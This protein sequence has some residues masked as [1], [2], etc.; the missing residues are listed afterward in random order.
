MFQCLIL[1]SL[2]ITS[3]HNHDDEGVYVVNIVINK[4]T[5][6]QTVTKNTVMPIDVSMTRDDKGVIHN[7]KMEIVNATSSATV[8]TLLDKHHHE[9]GTFNY[10][11]AAYKPQT[12]GSFKLKITVTDDD[13]LQPNVKE[14]AFSVN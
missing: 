11:E 6:N 3:C 7:V 2:F 4:P 5:V 12:V 14:V 1:I 10:I 8:E 9:S 13:K